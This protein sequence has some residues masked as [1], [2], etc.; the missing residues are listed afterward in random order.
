M[1]RS[2]R[3]LSVVSLGAACL[4]TAAPPLLTQDAGAGGWL[5]VYGVKAE[6]MQ[7][8]KGTP[9]MA[10]FLV[11][12]SIVAAA[13][14]N[15]LVAGYVKAYEAHPVDLAVLKLSPAGDVLWSK[16]YGPAKDRAPAAPAVP[17]DQC[18]WAALAALEDGGALVGFGDILL[19]VDR[20]G[21][22]A[23]AYSLR[24]SGAGSGSGGRSGSLTLKAVSV[25]GGKSF[26]VAGVYT[27]PPKDKSQAAIFAA[28]VGADGSVAWARAYPELRPSERPSLLVRPK[29]AWVLGS[30]PESI[31]GVDPKTGEAVWAWRVIDQPFQRGPKERPDIGRL[32]NYRT[33]GLASNG[34]IIFSGVY[35]LSWTTY[36][37]PGILIARLNPDASGV[38]WTT[39]FHGPY[40][41]GFGA[42]NAVKAA[43]DDLYLA[44]TSTDFGALDPLM[45]NNILAAKMS[46]SGALQWVR[47]I[48]KKKQSQAQS[49]YCNEMANDLALT[50]DGGLI[51]AGAANS[52]AHPDPGFHRVVRWADMH[53]DLALARFTA[54]GG[55]ANLPL[56]RYP[57]IF[58]AAD[59]G[60]PK[61]VDV[62]HPP[63]GVLRLEGTSEKLSIEMRRADYDALTNEI[64]TQVTTSGGGPDALTPVAD[65]KLLPPPSEGSPRVL[66]DASVSAASEGASILRYSWTFGDGKTGTGVKP[67]HQ[68]PSA[69]TWT[70]GLTVVDNKGREATVSKQV[71]VGNLVRGKGIPAAFAPE[72]K[73]D[74]T[75]EVLTGDVGD[76][77]TNANVF[78]ALY[79][80]EDENGR[81]EASGDMSLSSESETSKAADPFEQGQKNAFLVKGQWS[82]DDVEHM[83]LRHDNRPD[84]PGWYV[85]GVKVTN[86]ATKD[87]WV[88]V[89]DQWLADDEGP[90]HR[91]WGR[92]EPVDPYPAGVL[93]KGDPTCSG[94]TAASD[95]IVILEDGLT[96]FY[97]TAC[98]KGKTTQV[99]YSSG[100]ALGS[101]STGGSGRIAF[102]YLRKDEW[103]V[104]CETG[105][106]TK[107]ESFRVTVG[108]EETLVW[109]FP[110]AWKGYEKEA[111]RIALLYPLRT[112]TAV[113]DY[114]SKSK[115]FLQA[116]TD[117][118]SLKQALL[119]ILDYGAAALGIFG[120]I[121]DER[122]SWYLERNTEQY[123]QYKALKVAAKILNLVE[124]D[125]KPVVSQF[126]SIMDTLWKAKNWAERLPDVIGLSADAPNANALL[127]H[128]TDNDRTYN[129][130]IGVFAGLKTKFNALTAALDA[131]NPGT[132]RT[133]IEDLRDISVGP[134]PKSDS[135]ASH[136]IDYSDYGITR[137][138]SGAGGDYPLSLL[139]IIEFNAMNGW[140]DD[141]H[142]FLKDAWSKERSDMRKTLKNYEPPWSPVDAT[143][144]ALGTF[145]PIIENISNIASIFI[146]TA[147]CVDD[148]D[149]QWIF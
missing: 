133:L 17:S 82:L 92:F 116:Q 126:F 63:L 145:A 37:A 47:S 98:E 65:F 122:L 74:Y 104:K 112:R 34:D 43:G 141:G 16:E 113:F 23:W 39:R 69:G 100:V 52:F 134:D 53:Y 102:P 117:A 142:P 107:P 26:A 58:S 101:W 45:N 14:G 127:E 111:R 66:F 137:V 31:A 136:L 118:F 2:G 24:P 18:G 90:D 49:E 71:V 41:G 51:L 59:P 56:G 135:D 4:L 76:A 70:V 40:H 46:G 22:P 144:L 124:N 60:N 13:D 3:I 38:Q 62:V 103:G 91:T 57:R 128:L 83:I 138:G 140:R 5:R 9:F 21:R 81:R 15:F 36:K 110:K 73:A 20:N 139:L 42:V 75:I 8:L 106:I 30:E 1:K 79:G 11:G 6:E 88:F 146:D 148:K 61:E 147:L 54:G 64:Q 94:L 12:T 89:P 19:R 32:L 97:F 131:N 27:P 96:E 123:A 119:P 121:P 55:I 10:G 48:G 86:N 85:Q 78:V 125:L 68:Y 108:D 143:R 33:L 149:P 95:N 72:T 114:P 99:F 84:K 120:N 93:L 80:A 29:G 7:V 44:G 87:E 50:P 28:R 109:V 77:G 129:Q 35:N 130:V 67:W 105:K 115:S 25:L 132:A